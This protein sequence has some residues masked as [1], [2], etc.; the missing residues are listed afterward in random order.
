M[1]ANAN[2]GLTSEQIAEAVQRLSEGRTMREMADRLGMPWQRLL[3]VLRD[4]GATYPDG[5]PVTHPGWSNRRRQ[6]GTVSMPTA[7][8]PARRRA[9]RRE[10]TYGIEIECTVPAG[11][12]PVGSYHSGAQIDGLPE[13]WKAKTD[14]SIRPAAGFDG[15]EII[16]PILTGADG[17]RQIITVCAWL[18][19]A[20]AKV[21]ASCGFHVHVGWNASRT[22]LARLIRL[23]A[24]NERGLFAATG[25]KQREQS[26]YTQPISTSPVYRQA[27]AVNCRSL[28]SSRYQSLN[29]TNLRPSGKNTVEFRAFAGT[30]NATKILAYVSLCLGF[31][32]KAQDQAATPAEWDFAQ[33]HT[34]T[35]CVAL[36]R[37]IEELGWGNCTNYGLIQEPTAPTAIDMAFELGRLAQKYDGN[38]EPESV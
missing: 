11:A 8:R 30:T 5:R 36:R 19:R 37:L 1:P 29:L 4:A 17:V 32:T 7:S 24:K 35:G 26:H 25:T 9:A 20:G 18:A 31:V 6:G 15:V 38:A 22:E 33:A 23:V 16:S 2:H 28:P 21:N 27:A 12:I 10:L 14:G 34:A 3:F 13:G